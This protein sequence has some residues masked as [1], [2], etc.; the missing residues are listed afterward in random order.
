MRVHQRDLLTRRWRNVLEPPS[1]AAFHI[2]LVSILRWAIRPNVLWWH[3]PNGGYRNAREAAKLKAMGTLPGVS[4]LQFHWVEIDKLHRRIRHVLHLELK[5]KNGLSSEAQASFAL[6]VKLL[7][8][9]YE[10]ARSVDDALGILRACGLLR[11]DVRI[12]H[13][14]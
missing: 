5:A 14:L 13:S 8:D 10:I 12:E 2:Q 11:N 4:D 6:A 7:G 3:T 9:D 1:E